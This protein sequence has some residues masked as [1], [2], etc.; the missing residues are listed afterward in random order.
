MS[1]KGK[2]CDI[3]AAL[4]DSIQKGVQVKVILNNDVDFSKLEDSPIVRN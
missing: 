2:L 4:Y 1:F 3:L